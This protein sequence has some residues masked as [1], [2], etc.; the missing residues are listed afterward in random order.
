MRSMP[1][2][3]RACE[4]ASLQPLSQAFGLPA[5]LHRGA[6]AVSRVDEGIDPYLLAKALAALSWNSCCH[7]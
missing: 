7:W 1:E 3:I 2:G 4:T 6:L 5:P